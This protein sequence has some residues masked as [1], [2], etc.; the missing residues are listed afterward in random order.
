MKLILQYGGLSWVFCRDLL[1]ATVLVQSN[2]IFYV[3]VSV[4]FPIEFL[5]LLLRN[6]TVKKDL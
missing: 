4:L 3:P 6:Q 2:S 1:F 5:S